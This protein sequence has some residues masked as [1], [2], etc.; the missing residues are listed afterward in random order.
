MRVHPLYGDGAVIQRDRPFSLMGSASPG[1]TIRLDSD[2]LPPAL[3]V[4]GA[5]GRFALELPPQ[6]AGGPIEYRLT[7]GTARRVV[8]DVYFGDV[9]LASG[10]S[11]MQWTVD[12]TDD[13]E[14][15][16]SVSDDLL[17][18]LNVPNRP[19]EQPRSTLPPETEW[20]A[21]EPGQTEQFSGV[22]FYFAEALRKRY[23]EL[24]VG[25]VNCS[26]GG[27]RIEAW[28]PAEI[29]GEPGSLEVPADVRENWRQL[30]ARYPEAFA[31]GGNGATR[32]GVGGQPTE[33]G[34]RWEWAGYAGIDGEIFFDRRFELT[35]AQ[36]AAPGLLALGAIDDSDSTWVNGAFV[37][38]M[39][40][41][42]AKTRR[43]PLPAT[44]LKGGENRVT[45]WIDD[46]GGQGG[47]VGPPDS[48][49][50][51]AAGD[52]VA[53]GQGWTSRP[54]RL[55]LDSLRQAQQSPTLLYNGM[56]HPLRGVRFAAALWY[57]GESNAGDLDEVAAYGRQLRQLVGVVRELSD[58]TT[59]PVLVVELPEWQAVAMDAYEDGATWPAMRWQQQSALAGDSLVASVVTLGYGDEEDIHPTAKRP[60]GERLAL[61]AR[62][63]VYGEEGLARQ[64]RP[65]ELEPFGSGATIR[66][67][68]VGEGLRLTGGEQV[69]RLAVRDATGRWHAAEGEVVAPDRLR[70]V[71]PEDAGE[72]RAVAYAWANTPRGANLVN[73]Y[74][75]PVSSFRLS[76]DE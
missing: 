54:K 4:A 22:G 51:L 68:G 5:D 26:W 60:V 65:V 20:E 31:D 16:A 57:Q 59:L 45:V 46:T 55:A 70:V 29:V 38:A 39:E 63:L 23:P 18:H 9:F 24:P 17:R 53:L 15:A 74:G 71:A 48:I 2:A 34:K 76:L 49:Y 8:R 52:T 58:Q 36:A 50:L 37:G 7:V 33:V 62:T 32:G 1:D 75:W 43:Y 13:A 10:Q 47:M 56:L 66:F 3:A 72:V 30:L 61:A 35:P 6:P 73:S 67:S 69:D 11:N 14:R 21:A 12:N 28:L 27:S 42:Y 19:A 40:S 64:A 44:V 25:I 41:A